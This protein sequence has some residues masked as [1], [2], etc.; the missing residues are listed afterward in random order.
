MA[1]RR[2]INEESFNKVRSLLG[3]GLKQK[4]VADIIGCSAITVSRI[5]RSEAENYAAWRA[6]AKARNEAEQKKGLE[7]THSTESTEAMDRVGEAETEDFVVTSPYDI[8]I[9]NVTVEQNDTADAIRELTSVMREL[10]E[11]WE[12]NQA[13]KRRIF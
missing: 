4:Q 5:N 11:A 8:E 10:V 9:P 2:Q 13:K 6:E 1:K 12:G 7:R 3:Y